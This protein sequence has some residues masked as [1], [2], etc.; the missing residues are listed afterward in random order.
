MSTTPATVLHAITDF[1]RD[2]EASRAKPHAVCRFTFTYQDHSVGPV[3][4][5]RGELV[6]DIGH[7]AVTARPDAFDIVHGKRKRSRR[8][9]LNSAPKVGTHR[10]TATTATN[11]PNGWLGPPPVP[12]ADN[13]ELRD[14]PGQITVSLGR[15]A[16]QTIRS[17]AVL[18]RSAGLETGGQLFVSADDLWSWR[19]CI[20]LLEASGPGSR[21]KHA[22]SSLTRDA[23]H[24]IQTAHAIESSGLGLREAGH[25]HVHP[26]GHDVPSAADL[27]AWRSLMELNDLTRFVGLIITPADTGSMLSRMSP[28]VMQRG[29]YDGYVCER[30][31]IA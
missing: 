30:A 17:E 8:P 1:E 2:R 31:V 25:W 10:A 19:P 3:T 27:V 24:E 28:W 9:E 7:E 6:Y 16:D 23:W 13:V 18:F 29:K 15:F 20:R 22:R 21:A 14:R 12:R 5:S 26:S 11:M 4:I